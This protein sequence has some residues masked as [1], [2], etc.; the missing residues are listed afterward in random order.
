MCLLLL[1]ITKQKTREM[2][3]EVEFMGA[4]ESVA[5]LCSRSECV[6]VNTR[7]VEREQRIWVIY[8]RMFVLFL[9]PCA[10]YIK[11]AHPA[12]VFNSESSCA[13]VGVPGGRAGGCMS[14][15]GPAEAPSY[16][17]SSR[18][19]WYMLKWRQE[20]RW[21]ASRIYWRRA[22]HFWA[23]FMSLRFVDWNFQKIQFHLTHDGVWWVEMR[24][25]FDLVELDFDRFSKV[26]TWKWKGWIA[27]IKFLWE[28]TSSKISD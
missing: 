12:G 26:M 5:N 11:W 16:Y 18:E 10:M 13:C 21:R 4:S 14:E 2:M 27:L 25:R 7:N 19:I 15:G 20:F 24:G 9:A 17:W 22:S 8:K 28:L 1:R 3:A 6:F 23:Q